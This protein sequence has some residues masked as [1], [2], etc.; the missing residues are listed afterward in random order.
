MSTIITPTNITAKWLSNALQQCGIDAEVDTFDIEQ[1]GTGQLGETRRFHLR[2]RGTPAPN[3]PRTVVG[4][5]PSDNDVAATTGQEMGFY[6]SE[7]M[8]YRD[9]AH[10]A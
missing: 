10:R 6:R 5:F 3:A 7:V 2:Y 1:V 4:K 8:F 9:L